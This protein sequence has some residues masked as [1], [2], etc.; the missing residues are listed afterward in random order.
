MPQGNK[1]L[2]VEDEMIISMEI[3]QKLRG[4]GYEAVPV[5]K[6]FSITRTFI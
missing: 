1:I 5:P 4:M 3:K 2:I 6:E